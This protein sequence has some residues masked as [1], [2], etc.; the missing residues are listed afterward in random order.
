MAKLLYRIGREK[1]IVRNICKDKNPFLIGRGNG[2]NLVFPDRRVSTYH[3]M[4]FRFNGDLYVIDHSYNG[5]FYNP[6]TDTFGQK[7]KIAT[8]DKEVVENFE[9]Q[10]SVVELSREQRKRRIAPIPGYVPHKF[11]EREDIE[12]LVK[13]AKDPEQVDLLVSSGR[14]LDHEG[15]IGIPI[16]KSKHR[17]YFRMTVLHPD[18]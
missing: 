4:I 2:N 17:Q 6:E 13:I 12:Y 8:I 10:K 15:H 3:A 18:R 7:T 5:T 11:T 14:K 16:G 1:P 9:R